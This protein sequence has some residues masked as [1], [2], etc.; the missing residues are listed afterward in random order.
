MNQPTAKP[1]HEF[2][3]A[4]DHRTTPNAAQS[5][6]LSRF[7]R[8]AAQVVWPA[9]LG[10]AMSVGLFF[11]AIDPLEIDLVAEHLGGSSEGA[12]TVGFFLFWVLFMITGS[13]TW[14]L[15]NTDNDQS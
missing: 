11:S 10:A 5:G 9:F 6:R 12:Y 1:E 13:I 3:D 8:G 4:Q 2:D 7:A 15:A 14:L